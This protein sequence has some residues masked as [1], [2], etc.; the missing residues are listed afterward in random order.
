MF[1]CA[2]GYQYINAN[3]GIFRKDGLMGA[4]YP[5]IRCVMNQ[6]YIV[7]THTQSG[8]IKGRGQSI[9]GF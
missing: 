8:I 2:N 6:D 4:T 7:H 1:H 5:P 9:F 3:V